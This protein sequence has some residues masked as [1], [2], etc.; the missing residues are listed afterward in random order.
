M[1]ATATLPLE[2]ALRDS[3]A[4]VTIPESKAEADL[5]LASL[6]SVIRVT[7]H[8]TLDPKPLSAESVLQFHGGRSI[9]LLNTVGR[10]QAMLKELQV[11]LKAS[12]LTITLILLH[13]HFFKNDRQIKEEKLHFLF[14]KENKG[15]A[16]LVAT[17]VVEAGL[18]ISCSDA[19]GLSKIDCNPLRDAHSGATVLYPIRNLPPAQ[20]NL[21]TGEPEAVVIPIEAEPLD[22]EEHVI[23]D[24]IRMV[25]TGDTSQV[26][27]PGFGM[28]LSRK[29]ERLLVRQGKTV[30]YEFPLFRL[31][32]VVVASRGVTLSSDLIEVLCQRGIRLSFLTGGGK[33]YAMLS[34]PML[35]AT[36]ISR[37]QQLA[38]IDDERGV[39]FA[40]LIVAGS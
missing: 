33:P 21:Y 8:I 16:I 24:G 11:A 5:L 17:Q 34:S 27:L 9:V 7:R 39:L 31:S 20:I 2:N 12:G 36:V 37:R 35:T 32:E 18:D 15:P 40:K 14:G 22:G 30:V 13:S 23:D 38:A 26:V 10:A 6:P 29:S 1:T 3:L 28:F 25:K 19:D 4:T